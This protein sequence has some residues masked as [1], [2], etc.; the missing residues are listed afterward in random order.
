MRTISAPIIAALALRQ[1]IIRWFVSITPRDI[2]TGDLLS[3]TNFW[4]GE[5]AVSLNV[6]DGQSGATVARTYSGGG[7]ISNMDQIVLEIG[8]GVR[9]VQVTL[10][11]VDTEVNNFVR[12]TQLR[13][14]QVEIHFGLFDVETRN[15]VAAFPPLFVGMVNKA[16]LSTGAIFHLGGGCTLEVASDTRRLS[17]ISGEKRSDE[18]QQKRAAGDRFFKDAEVMPGLELFWGLDKG[19]AGNVSPNRTISTRGRFS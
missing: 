9:T 7:K 19:K 6:I 18:S 16:T 11:M 4:T 10:N 2:V 12:G 3:P 1:L 8:L 14:A 17:K 13:K 5:S 15:P